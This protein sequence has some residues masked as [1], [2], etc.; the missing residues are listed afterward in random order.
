MSAGMPA[1]GVPVTSVAGAIAQ[2]EAIGSAL[3]AADGLACF[4]R[5]YLDVTRQVN[6]QLNA[7]FFADPAF[8]AYLDVAFANLYLAAAAAAG[9]RAAVPPAWLPL[10]DQRATA[11][12]EP[13]QF[14]LAGMNAHINHDLPIAMVDTCAALGTAPDAGPHYA[15]YQKVDQLLDA[16]EQSIRQ[17]FETGAEL[18]VDRHL[19]AVASLVAS[20]TITSAR[21]LA[22]TNCLLLWAVRDDPFVRQ[23]VLD[24]LATS[25]ALASRML[26]VPV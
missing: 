1:P 6:S 3:P 13:V 10:I 17:S 5:M 19:S 16:A 25:T 2:M 21:D 24:A 11:G 26:L 15:D 9:T 4:N 12:I 23:L 18:A 14:A 7:G 22:W 8:M 20:W